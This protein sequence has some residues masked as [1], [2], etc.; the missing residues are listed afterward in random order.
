MGNN[1][2]GIDNTYQ[3][4]L[5]S[6]GDK[7][8]QLFQGLNL[9]DETLIKLLHQGKFD[10][11]QRDFVFQ[12]LENIVGNVE[13]NNRFT[14]AL[15][16][17]S[18]NNNFEKYI[19]LLRTFSYK[20]QDVEHLDSILAKDNLHKKLVK[21][22]HKIAESEKLTIQELGMVIKME[23]A[24]NKIDFSMDAINVE[25]HPRLSS[26]M[27]LLQYASDDDADG[28]TDINDGVY[29]SFVN[30]DKVRAFRGESIFPLEKL[31]EV[32]S[33]NDHTHSALV[34]KNGGDINLSH[35]TYEGYGKR[36]FDWVDIVQSNL[37]S[38]NVVKL[39]PDHLL[40]ALQ[41]KYGV[42]YENELNRILKNNMNELHQEHAEKLETLVLT[43]SNQG[44]KMAYLADFMPILG[45]EL[46]SEQEFDMDLFKEGENIRCSQFMWKMLVASLIKTNADLSAELEIESDIVDLSLFKTENISNISSDRIIEK[47]EFC[48]TKPDVVD[49]YFN[50]ISEQQ[51]YGRIES[52][53]VFARLYHK[54]E[55]LITEGQ[56]SEDEF[57]I[58][59]QELFT[60][61]QE[62]G[63]IKGD[64]ELPEMQAFIN[65]FYYAQG[66]SNHFLQALEMFEGM[67]IVVD[68]SNLQ[69]PEF[70][71]ECFFDQIHADLD[72]KGYSEVEKIEY[73]MGDTLFNVTNK[74]D[75][76]ENSLVHYAVANNRPDL[77]QLFVKYQADI[78][79]ENKEGITPSDMVE[80]YHLEADFANFRDDAGDVILGGESEIAEAA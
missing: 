69:P 52:E 36:E 51:L 27:K 49:E 26:L 66:S 3:N 48:L 20:T 72:A 5:G 21:A 56:L 42:N 9:R 67:G 73:L 17:N 65:S 29:L 80:L 16:A 62:V 10:S 1:I 6:Q 33:L 23:K 14:N 34:F 76:N 41:Q 44:L 47:L 19:Q 70:N 28:G 63:E 11:N 50:K 25:H 39:I 8:S 12:A 60:I 37:Y 43:R 53:D 59:S 7:E 31:R 22:G 35:V 38:F 68:K 74:C 15:K 61:Y 58:K 64:I 30:I 75:A 57:M 32:G 79:I 54:M 46:E 2:S 55:D 4:L 78:S 71:D 24:I 13:A 45:H 18:L 40:P 77:I